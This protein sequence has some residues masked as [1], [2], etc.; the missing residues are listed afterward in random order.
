MSM[1]MLALMRCARG[2]RRCSI[3]SDIRR[4]TMIYIIATFALPIPA[5]AGP[6]PPALFQIE[7]RGERK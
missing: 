7:D 1:L 6:L 3:H 4:D 5:V 2:R